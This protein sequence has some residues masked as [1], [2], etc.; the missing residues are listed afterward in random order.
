MACK[1]FFSQDTEFIFLLICSSLGIFGCLIIITL[2]LKNKYM[3]GYFNTLILFITIS[4]I[5]RST[6]TVIPCSLVSSQ[7]LVSIFG[8][9]IQSSLLISLLWSTCI[10]L[11][12]HSVFSLSIPDFEKH[13][14]NWLIICFVLVPL[15]MMLPITTNSYTKTD[16]VCD[17][18]NN[19]TGFIWKSCLIFIPSAVCIITSFVI[20]IKIHSKIKTAN[21]SS[22]KKSIIKRVSLFPVVMCI[23]VLPTIFFKVFE[24]FFDV[25]IV[26]QFN[27]L[28]L[29]IF[30]LNGFFN[31]ILF[32][33]S[34][35]AR[36]KSNSSLFESV[37]SYNSSSFFSGNLLD[38]SYNIPIKN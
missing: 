5:L 33:L 21:I 30:A 16:H 13:K 27:I 8:I 24:S 9:I 31:M 37:M 36:G 1:G 17:L 23:D 34:N 26:G 32:I 35:S 12:L 2:Q 3:R 4:D 10:L 20:C 11:T 18:D 28:A 29:G 7:L 38:E 6:F 15:I 14:K 19:L 25:C 22:Q